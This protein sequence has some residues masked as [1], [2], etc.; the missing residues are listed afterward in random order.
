MNLAPKNAIL[1]ENA[2]E[3]AGLTQSEAIRLIA[4]FLNK[5]AIITMNQFYQNNPNP[6]LGPIW[7]QALN[8]I[9]LPAEEAQQSFTEWF[10]IAIMGA[11]ALTLLIILIL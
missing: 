8:S 4:P 11:I 1:A 2:L 9:V 6:V 5:N 3:N 10:I 7:S